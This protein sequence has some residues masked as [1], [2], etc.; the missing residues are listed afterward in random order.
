MSVWLE[1]VL[2]LALALAHL[3]GMLTTGADETAKTLVSSVLTMPDELILEQALAAGLRAVETLRH[4]SSVTADALLR[5][6]SLF[7]AVVAAA[8]RGRDPGGG[9]LAG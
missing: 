4:V 2:A 5:R 6:E 1:R 3:S 7:I 9:S 8:M